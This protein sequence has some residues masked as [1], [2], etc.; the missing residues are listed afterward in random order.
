MLEGMHGVFQKEI[1][2]LASERAQFASSL[3][4]LKLTAPSSPQK[5]MVCTNVLPRA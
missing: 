1:E 3:K 2:A 5:S 4:Q